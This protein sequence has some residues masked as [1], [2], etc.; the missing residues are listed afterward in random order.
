MT[1]LVVPYLGCNLRCRH[2]FAHGYEFS[3]PDYDLEAILK[4]MEQMHQKT[5]GDSFCMHGGECTLIPKKDFEIIL[6][7]MTELQG[8]SAIQTNCYNIDNDLIELFKKY[9]TSIGASLDGL[10]EL[11]SLRGFPYDPEKTNEYTEKAFHNM[12]NMQE[13]GLNVGLI[14]VLHK[15]N[16]S[17]TEKLQKLIQFIM[18]LREHKIKGGRLNMMW[19]NNP[20]AKPYELTPE[21]ASQAWL[22]LYNNLKTYPDLQWQPFRDFTDNLLGFS[23]SSCTYG[24]CDYFCTYGARVILSD[25]SLGNCDRTHQEGCVYTRAAEKPSY[26]RYEALKA[27]DCAK[28]RFWN[29]CYG[30]C[31]AEG[32]DGDWRNKTRFCKPTYDLYTAIEGD[33][34]AMLPNIKLVTDY[35]SPEDYFDALR[36]GRRINA[37]EKMLFATTNN[38]SSWKCVQTRASQQLRDSQTQQNRTVQN[39]EHGDV[40]HGDYTD[41]GDSSC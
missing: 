5:G 6:K 30:G 28:C 29:V 31:P 36:H 13:Q 32:I 19:T 33:I 38:P 3:K 23:H 40:P 7:K 17:S 1:V 15:M 35:K 18:T 39:R 16:A 12:I 10:G 25:G 2:C 14:T 9:K 41:H 27:T 26:E 11:N 8:K 22:Y 37:F 4:S 21:E 34:R 24:K 20:E